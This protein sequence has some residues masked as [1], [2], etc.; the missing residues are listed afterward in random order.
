MKAGQGVTVALAVRLSDLAVVFS[1]PK[2]PTMLRAPA[3]SPRMLAGLVVSLL[4]VLPAIASAAPVQAVQIGSVKDINSGDTAWMLVS[5]ALVLLMTGPGLA[6]FYCGLV[7]RKN[8]LATMMQSFFLMGAVSM[9]WVVVGYSLAFDVGNGFI[10]GF[11]FAFLNNV[12]AAPCEYAGTIPHTTW[13][14]YQMMFAI[15]TPALICGAYAER[16][17]FSSMVVF[18][19][20]WLLGVYCPMAHMIWG[21]GGWMNA[22]NPSALFPVLDFAGGIVVH[23]TSGVSALVCALMLGKR[24]GYGTTPMPPHSVVLSVIGAALLWVGW[25]GFNAGS[26]GRANE[27]ASSAFFATHLAG[28]AAA[29]S[30]TFVEWLK[31]GKPTVLGAISGA[32]AGLAMITPASGFTTPMYALLIGLIAGV[33]CFFGATLLKQKLGYDD[34]LDAFGVHGVSGTLGPILAGVFAVAAINGRSGWVEG[35]SRQVAYQII[36]VAAAWVL[37][38]V[39]TIV[40]LKLTSAICGLRVSEE[41]EYDG[42]DLVLHGESG[43]NLE[44]DAFTVGSDEAAPRRRRESAAIGVAAVEA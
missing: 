13:A 28:A 44:D 15:I 2:E 33:A 22:S 16:M 31:T 43:Y 14:I 4:A 36:A 32:V 7:R 26:A 42:L 34:T 6:L 9:V 17:K 21:K 39:G 40:L 25:F 3:A 37:S 27:L 8:V 12:G 24:Q 30:W 11:H 41:E 35:N 38:I 19:I 18:S 23:A 29:C 10:G 20:F 1:R 5:S